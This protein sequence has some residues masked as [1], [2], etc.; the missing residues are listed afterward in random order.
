M[1]VET[2]EPGGAKA[3][4]VAPT[5]IIGEATTTETHER[6]VVYSKNPDAW[7]A[8]VRDAE[9][10]LLGVELGLDADNVYL[11]L[12]DLLGPPPG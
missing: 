3:G 8:E 4:G 11:D 6:T 1:V 10:N 7:L 2:P 9:G 5:E 12:R